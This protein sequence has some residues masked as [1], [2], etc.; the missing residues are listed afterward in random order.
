MDEEMTIT[1]AEIEAFAERLTGFA[2][3]LNATERARLNA[4]LARAVTGPDADTAGF[5]AADGALPQL[6]A[7]FAG[8]RSRLTVEG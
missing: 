7:F 6:R 8:P 4:L 5:I 3:T 2:A 1:H